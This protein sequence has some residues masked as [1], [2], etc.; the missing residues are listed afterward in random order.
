MRAAPDTVTGGRGAPRRRRRRKDPVTRARLHEKWVFA[1]Q[2]RRTPTPAERL[3]RQHLYR[4]L[5]HYIPQFMLYG[6]VVDFYAPSIR[7]AVEID[8]EIH[9]RADIAERDAA[10]TRSLHECGIRLVRLTNAQVFAD[11]KGCANLLLSLRR[12]DKVPQWF[13]VASEA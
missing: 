7:T 8:G 4:R 10:K 9:A 13:T 2:L 12:G 1:A 6:W 11:P 5:P 3:L